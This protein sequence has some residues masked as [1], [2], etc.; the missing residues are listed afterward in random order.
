[1]KKFWKRKADRAV[2]QDQEERLAKAEGELKDL[3]GRAEVAVR[4]L[5]DRNK[6]NHWRDAVTELINGSL[7]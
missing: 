6:R 5:D 1:M 4:I 7:L 3:K 2:E